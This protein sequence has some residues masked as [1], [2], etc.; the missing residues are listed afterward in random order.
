MLYDGE[1]IVKYDIKKHTYDFNDVEY[2]ENIVVIPGQFKVITEFPIKYWGD[3]SNIEIVINYGNQIDFGNSMDVYINTDILHPF[4]NNGN[5]KYYGGLIAL[6]FNYNGEKYAIADMVTQ[7]HMYDIEKIPNKFWE[8]IM[9]SRKFRVNIIIGA[10]IDIYN[11]VHP[12][13]ILYINSYT[14]GDDE[15]EQ[16]NMNIDDLLVLGRD[17]YDRNIQKEYCLYPCN[18]QDFPFGQYAIGANVFPSA[19]REHG[20]VHVLEIIQE[21]KLHREKPRKTQV[22]QLLKISKAKLNQIQKQQ[23]IQTSQIPFSQ[24]QFSQISI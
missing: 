14:N 5:I 21:Y 20:R 2:V 7:Y 16:N 24:Q 18:T 13:N 9:V 12:D 15:E 23:T 11:H 19:E 1:N 6:V 3:L 17:I 22:Q 4:M 10:D 8:N